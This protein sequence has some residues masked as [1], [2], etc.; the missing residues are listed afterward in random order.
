VEENQD[1]KNFK[2]VRPKALAKAALER[3][4]RAA[5]IAEAT[6]DRKNPVMTN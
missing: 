5:A 4:Q 3:K 6:S 1:F 2:D